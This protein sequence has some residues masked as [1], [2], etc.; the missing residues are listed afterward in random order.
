VD[1][2]RRQRKSISVETMTALMKGFAHS[3]QIAKAEKLFNSMCESRSKAGYP[4]LRTFNTLL[5]GC[6]WC[7]GTLDE[8][9][10]VG[11]VVTAER[12]WTKYKG[13]KTS[14]D[15]AFD[16]SS[17]EYSI[18][19]LCQALRTKDAENRIA[20]MTTAFDIKNAES[21]DQSATEVLANTYLALAR[22]HS[23]LR[24]EKDT[25]SACD[26]SLAFS[27]S[28]RNALKSDQSFSSMYYISLSDFFFR[29]VGR[30]PGC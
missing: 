18:T 23:V 16:V 1:E 26:M 3:G 21:N 22:A 7:P 11:G 19:L 10:V 28:S 2:L 24:S 8:D 13:L 5:R 20:E 14:K 30:M 9:G 27:M 25:V 4:N 29:L 12:A 15:E 17:Y 6:L